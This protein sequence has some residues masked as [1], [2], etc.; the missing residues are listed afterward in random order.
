MEK[1]D[2][3]CAN[4]LVLGEEC[5]PGSCIIDLSDLS[6]FVRSAQTIFEQHDDLDSITFHGPYTATWLNGDDQVIVEGVRTVVYKDEVEV[7]A[8]PR[9]MGSSEL[10]TAGPIPVSD[11]DN[12]QD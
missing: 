10:L 4:D 3:S 6:G 5:I 7:T 8:L 12:A 2:V 11:F 9:H 1:L